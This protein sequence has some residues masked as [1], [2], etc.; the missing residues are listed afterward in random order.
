MYIKE[1]GW[2]QYLDPPGTDNL[3]LARPYAAQ[4]NRVLYVAPQYMPFDGASMPR[5]PLGLLWWLVGPPMR[6][7]YRRG[8]VIHDGGYKGVL[9][10]FGA[11]LGAGDRRRLD[12]IYAEG[13]MEPERL[14][15]E[16]GPPLPVEREETDELLR[17]LARANGT[18]RRRADA[19]HW[20]VA[21]F[22]AK[23]WAR[24]HEKYAAWDGSLEQAEDLACA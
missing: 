22:G 18:G 16:F 23:P 14:R 13:G 5:K 11:G 15:A 12:A 24:E 2:P 20:A 4:V 17:E 7:P 21:R 6:G 1:Y 9:L 10:A 19:M 3:L 8:C